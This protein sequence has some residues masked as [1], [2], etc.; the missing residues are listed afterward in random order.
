[1]K[2]AKNKNTKNKKVFSKNSQDILVEELIQKTGDNKSEKR[3]QLLVN[4]SLDVDKR[5]FLNSD[6]DRVEVVI[7]KKACLKLKKQALLSN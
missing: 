2:I 3:K 1:M 7:S 5:Q 6:V 4:F